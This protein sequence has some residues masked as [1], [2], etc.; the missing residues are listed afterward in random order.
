MK[1]IKLVDGKFGITSIINLLVGKKEND[2]LAIPTD[3]SLKNP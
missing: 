3:S 2:Y 1:A